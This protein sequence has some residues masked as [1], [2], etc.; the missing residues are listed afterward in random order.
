VK[1]VGVGRKQIS[2]D[3][4]HKILKVDRDF[5]KGN[6][7]IELNQTSGYKILQTITFNLFSPKQIP[8]L[9]IQ[10]CC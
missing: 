5:K 3:E 9:Q 8:S 1:S 4:R 6:T 7:G 2:L 10:E